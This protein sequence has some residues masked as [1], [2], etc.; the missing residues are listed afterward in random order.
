MNKEKNREIDLRNLILSIFEDKWLIMLITGMFF[1]IGALY[2]MIKPAEYKSNA[3]IQIENK[4]NNLGEFDSLPKLF[5]MKASPSDVQK[6]LID[7]RFVLEPVVEQLSLNISAEPHYLPIFGAFIAR[8]HTDSTLAKPWLKYSRFAWGGEKIKIDQLDVA[9]KYQGKKLIVLSDGKNNYQLFSQ[10]YGFILAGTVGKSATTPPGAVDPV[11][12]L[13]SSLVANPG[14]QF[15]VQKTPASAII[16]T[17]EKNLTI[18]EIGSTDQLN[19]KT[20]ILELSLIGIKP[21]QLVDTLNKIVSVAYQEDMKNKSMEAAKTLDFLSQ[22]L[23][24]VKDSLNQAEVALNNYRAKSGKLN[25]NVETELFLNQIADIEKQI[26]ETQLKKEELLQFYTP[27]HPFIQALESRQRQLHEALAKLQATMK[28]LPAEDQVALSL[29]RDVR[30]KGELYLLLSKKM[31]ELQ[32]VAA[33]TVS[34]I[35]VLSLAK[36]PDEPLPRK[37]PLKLAALLLIGLLL[38]SLTSLVRRSWHHKIQDPRWIEENLGII[39][40]GIIPHSKK[41]NNIDRL[42]KKGLVSNNSILALSSPHDLSIEALRSLRTHLQFNLQ[43]SKNNIISIT[44]I[45]PGVGKSFVAGNFACLLADAG[46]RVL[47]IDGDIRRGH[48]YKYFKMKKSPGLSDLLQNNLN[49]SNVVQTM[50]NSRLDLLTAGTFITK[51]S[52]LLM[53]DAFN[54]L[55]Q[56]ASKAYDVVII[57]TAPILAVTDGVIVAKQAGINFL[58]I[59]SGMHQAEEI[60]FAVKRLY[61]NNITLQ[62]VIYNNVHNETGLYSY[63]KYRYRYYY[64]YEN[65]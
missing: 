14:T 42:I 15:I 22:Q 7:S 35:R 52:E 61:S 11:S 18:T 5:D 6:A 41:Q 10:K 25:L 27:E 59:G 51:P 8:H 40:A 36:L 3:L 57:D 24:E 62:G 55:L 32:V 60:E 63:G 29:A 19:I 31:Q 54:E 4:S 13:I 58:L 1:G 43:T 21:E 65:A 48:L 23:P 45:S 50:Q 20:G 2:I 38:G 12:I 28:K 9:P 33:G 39:T 16:D 30:V 64:D 34:D 56:T 17:L 53:S 47:L 44:G 46:K 49:L 37:I 26:G